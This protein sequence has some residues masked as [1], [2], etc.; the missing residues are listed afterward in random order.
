MTTRSM[1]RISSGG[2]FV[3][4]EDVGPILH[5]VAQ[6]L[7]SGNLT[8]GEYLRRFEA[9]FAEAVGVEHAIGMNSGTAPLEI[10]LRYAGV[11]G[12]EVIVP[13]NT[14]AASVNAALLAGARPVLADIDPSTLSSGRRQIEPLIGPSTRAVVAVHVAG[15][16]DP[17]F[18]DLVQLC[19]DRGLALVEDAAHA[20]GASAPSGRAGSLG[21]AGAFS[22][23][24][25]KVI[26]CGE[27]GMLTT[28]DA[29][30]ADLA[31]SWR[32]H[33]QATGDRSIVRVGHNYRLPEMSAAFGL[34]QLHRLDE[35]IETRRQLAER[36]RRR[37]QDDAGHLVLA[38]PGQRHPYYKLPLVLPPGWSREKVARRLQ[39]EFD[40]PTGTIYWPPCHRQPSFASLCEGRVFPIA[41]AVL[42]RTVALPMHSNLSFDDVDWVCDAVL[43][44]LEAGP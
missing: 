15:L 20:H 43:S 21:M 18:D 13:T 37:L 22:L 10:A 27:G 38:S 39:S 29:D 44:V 1:R 2:P 17:A 25:T 6:I 4:D 14:F 11:E 42:A 9:E 32:S 26:T 23:F 16:V 19:R 36:Y 41:D 33:G 7:R 12:G 40:V 3:P 8:Q 30:L 28:D 34:R 24:A 31:V 5:D 35:F